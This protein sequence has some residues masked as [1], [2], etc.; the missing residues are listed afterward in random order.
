MN[1]TYKE[2]SLKFIEYKVEYGNTYFF[3]ECP[4]VQIVL[5]PYHNRWSLAITRKKTV[6]NHKNQALHNW[7]VDIQENGNRAEGDQ[8]FHFLF[9][10]SPLRLKLLLELGQDFFEK[11]KPA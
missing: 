8:F 7:L 2:L 5:H 9:T 1:F 6:Y 11:N 3:F 10:Q 4:D